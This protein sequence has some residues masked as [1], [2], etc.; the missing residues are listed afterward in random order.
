M[1][2]TYLTKLSIKLFGSVVIIFPIIAW[3]QNATFS[4][5]VSTFLNTAPVLG[6]IAFSIMWLHITGS[7]FRTFLEKYM[8]FDRFVGQS[9]NIV[10]I[11]IILHPLLIVINV[12]FKNFLNYSLST[13]IWLG[14]I[15]FLMLI[16]YDIQKILSRNKFFEQ[17]RDK[18]LIISTLGFFVIFFHS[19]GIGS[20][21]QS[22]PLRL[23]WIFYG[24]TAA[25]ATIYTF[26]I[27]KETWAKNTKHRK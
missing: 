6:L 1:T 8:D 12:G 19:L 22:G 13:Y 18:V 27:K 4:S 2:H 7:A 21:L 9:S 20:T 26:L 16:T 15:G 25:L 11:L 14:I 23:V 17:Y 5:N 10:L 3:Y 24:I